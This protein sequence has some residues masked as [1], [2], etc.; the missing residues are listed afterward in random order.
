MSPCHLGP[1]GEGKA[2]SPLVPVMSLVHRVLLGSLGKK[3]ILLAE[4][5]QV[6]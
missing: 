5:G 6:S 3:N 2:A 4:K 1:R